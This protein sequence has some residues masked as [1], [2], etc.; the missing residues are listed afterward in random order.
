MQMS[1]SSLP[2]LH[3]L[4]VSGS[5]ESRDLGTCKPLPNPFGLCGSQIVLVGV[6]RKKITCNLAN[7]HKKIFLQGP[8]FTLR[9]TFRFS[10]SEFYVKDFCH[11]SRSAFIHVAAWPT[12]NP[13]QK[14]F[15]NLNISIILYYVI[16]CLYFF[17]IFNFFSPPHISKLAWY[18]AAL[19]ST[20][21]AR[22]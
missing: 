17:Q 21:K 7:L 13:N 14:Q 16:I 15:Q 9:Q 3:D 10:S 6:W 12:F 19:F 11:F 2:V 22:N 20:S 4:W 5:L 1:T 8:F 18:P